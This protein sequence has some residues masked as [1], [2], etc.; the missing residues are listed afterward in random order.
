[1][2]SVAV[3]GASQDPR[4]YGNRAVRAYLRRGWTVY[5]VNPNESVVEGIATFKAVTDI[6]APIDRATVYVPPSVG[7]TLL[8]GLKQKDIPEIFLNPGSEDDALVAEAERLGLNAI[9][10]CS[11]I[12]I[13]ERP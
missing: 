7:I 11:I 4:K 5:P 3:I 13:G 12:D 6:P 2:P 9:Q 1:M 8:P 10:A